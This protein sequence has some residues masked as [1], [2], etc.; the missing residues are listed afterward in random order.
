MTEEL[1]EKG[2]ELNKK[3]KDCK[4]ILKAFNSPYINIIRLNDYD[5]VRDTS[6]IVMLSSEPELEMHI[7]EYFIHKLD[8]LEQQLEKLK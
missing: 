7:R 1:L 2:N 4:K 5:G 8:A 3:I 6:Q